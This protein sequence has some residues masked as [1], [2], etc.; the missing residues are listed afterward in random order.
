MSS[1]LKFHSH[2]SSALKANCIL[3]VIAKSFTNQVQMS[4]TLYKSLV[5]QYQSHMGEM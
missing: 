4:P 3:S 5:S 2:S 1:N